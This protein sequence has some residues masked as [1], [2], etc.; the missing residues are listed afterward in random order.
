MLP[1]GAVNASSRAS[2]MTESD[3]GILSFLKRLKKRK[4]VQW[5]I[6]YFAGAWVLL[7]VFDLVA[8]QFLW[9]NWIRQTATILVLFGLFITIVLAWYHGERGRQ[10]IGMI[11]L[12]VLTVL[13]TLAGQ[14]VWVL[15][16]RAIEM[17][18]QKS[19]EAFSFRPEPLP[20]NSVAVLPCLNLSGD[21]NQEYFTDGLAAE[22]ITRLSAISELRV[23]SHTSSFSFK[24]QNLTIKE[25][26]SSLRVRHVLECDVTGD[27]SSL[28]VA[29][30]LVDAESGYTLWSASYI[31]S[32]EQLFEV[33]QDVAQA[34]VK[35]LK[36]KIRGSET[37][38]MA[39]RW[40]ENSEAYDH[41]LRA[42]KYQLSA[43]T[44]ENTA[45]GLEHIERA[46]ELDPTFGRAYARLGMTWIIVANFQ[47]ESP[48]EAYAKAERF[49][50]KAI[51][52]D[53]R[54][55]EAYWTLGWVKFSGGYAW[56]DAIDNFQNAIDLAPGEWVGY[57]SLG[58]VLGALGEIEQGLEAAW[59]AIDLNPLA[60]WPR[61]G[62]EALFT[63]QRDY[64]AAIRT[65]EAQAEMQG[66][67]PAMQL[68]YAGLLARVGR[69]EE[70]HELLEN[71]EKLA[72]SDP[73]TQ[74]SMALVY[75]ILGD[76][77]QAL[78]IVHTWEE[79]QQN[80]TDTYISAGYMAGVYAEL[81]M[82]DQA[83][84][85]LEK[86]R[87]DYDIMMIF[88]DLEKFDSLRQDPRFANF[89]HELDLPEEVY[90]QT[91]F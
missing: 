15:K 73:N 66:W 52:L 12:A 26:A 70:A 88:L 41:F 34:V 84:S 29:A 39:S 2:L 51:E 32:K 63:R 11:E 65:I 4:I 62:L 53:D 48:R 82:K 10:K 60:F 3:T 49:A 50:Q 58:F 64:E 27:Q 36:V 40:T 69:I 21:E 75:A 5:A 57:H 45:K 9:P 43:P 42:I 83:M 16:D 22:L 18:N 67:F 56:H 59:I 72:P 14:S 81:G 35:A 77:L 7:E 78:S 44:A 17:A 28:K 47:F 85:C 33:Q 54:L 90:L 61:R 8:E 79:E 31:H 76:D 1:T 46:V 19:S 89:I 6:A 80:E 74:L 13:L 68:R 30:R 55:Y 38:L 91:S 86:A 24:G 23:P 25:V 71:V 87:D 37:R 20:E